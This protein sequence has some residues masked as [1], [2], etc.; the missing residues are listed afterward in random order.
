MQ[1]GKIMKTEIVL[2]AGDALTLP[3]GGSIRLLRTGTWTEADA[4]TV[5]TAVLEVDEPDG[6]PSAAGAVN[7]P[8]AKT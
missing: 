3:A 5:T 7:T 4:P 6:T 8:A 2:K 1:S